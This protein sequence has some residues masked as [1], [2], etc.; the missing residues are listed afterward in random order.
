[1]R[2]HQKLAFWDTK[3]RSVKEIWKWGVWALYLKS[4]LLRIWTECTVCAWTSSLHSWLL[5]DSFSLFDIFSFSMLWVSY[6]LFPPPP[7]LP[8]TLFFSSCDLE[9]KFLYHNWREDHKSL[10]TRKRA[11]AQDV[12]RSVPHVHGGEGH[13]S[14]Q[15]ASCG[16]EAPGPVQ[17]LCL[18]QRDWRFST[19]EKKCLKVNLQ[20]AIRIFS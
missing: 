18:R 10:W 11:R 6:F 15:S 8:P 9:I 19:G 3:F 12:G 4:W 7:T 16:Q 20:K 2:Q 17:A 5:C 14:G 13:T 1:M